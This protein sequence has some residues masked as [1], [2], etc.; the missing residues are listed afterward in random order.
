MIKKILLRHPADHK[1]GY[2]LEVDLEYPK[3]LR[4]LH[5]DNPLAPEQLAP[6]QDWLSPYQLELMEEKKI[7]VPKEKQLMLTVMNKKNYVLHYRNLQMYCKL[8]LRVTKIHRIISFEQS[9]WMKNYIELNTELRK[10]AASEFEKNLYKLMNNA[11][12]GKT[13]ENLRNRIDVKFLKPNEREQFIKLALQPNFKRFQIVDNFSCAMEMHKRTLYLNKPIYVGMSILDLSKTVMYDFYYNN[14]KAK[15]GGKVG[16]LYTNT[17]SLTPEIQTDNVYE[18]MLTDM[19]SYDTSNF[20]KDSPLFSEKNNKVLGKMKDEWGG[21]TVQEFIGLRSKMYAMR[22][23]NDKEIKKAKGVKKYVVKKYTKFDEYK[24][25]L[26]NRTQ[27][28]K[29][30]NLLK[31]MRHQKYAIKMTKLSLCPLDM[32]CYICNDAV[33]TISFGIQNN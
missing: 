24:D 26:S 14:L 29:Q 20:D 32:K 17:D 30:M 31:S 13:M 9:A 4:M 21:V 15:Y 22:A 33:T 3:E 23:A 2:I 27:Y 1:T 5:N 18:D 25:A 28:Y 19:D 12:F 6:E 10:N 7:K 8:G 11:V 16:L